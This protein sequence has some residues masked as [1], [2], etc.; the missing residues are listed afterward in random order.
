MF[1]H[2]GKRRVPFSSDEWTSDPLDSMCLA[3]DVHGVASSLLKLLRVAILTR[4]DIK[5]SVHRRLMEEISPQ[6]DRKTS[7]E[8]LSCRD[9]RLP[10]SACPE[11]RASPFPNLQ[12][13]VSS[14]SPHIQCWIAVSRSHRFSSEKFNIDIE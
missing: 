5:G 11:S 3:A 7:S 10:L 13:T 6:S 1:C 12:E 8:L 4:K 2:I 9:S 14:L